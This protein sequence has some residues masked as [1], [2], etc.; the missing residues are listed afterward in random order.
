LPPYSLID[1]INNKIEPYLS[2]TIANIKTQEQVKMD[3]ARRKMFAINL[4]RNEEA[5]IL[6]LD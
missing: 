5:Y 4:T 6:I 1:K 2:Q 3:E